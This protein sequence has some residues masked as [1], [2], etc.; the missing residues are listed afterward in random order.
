MIKDFNLSP[1][2]KD[3][4][5][6]SLLIIAVTILCLPAMMGWSG[7]FFDDRATEMLPKVYF[8][9]HN[10]QRGIIPLWNPH[11]WCG[12]VPFYA[13]YYSLVYYL[14]MWPFYL[15]ANLNDINQTYWI[16][17]ILSL[18]LY[19]VI[20]AVGMYV[21]LRYILKY[22]CITSFLGAFIYIYSPSFIYA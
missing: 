16:T 7:I 4:L 11:I 17:V 5:A 22:S 6:V 2:N 1:V 14:P 12:A 13:N 21:L 19:Y 10:L 9:A 8:I 3:T 15:F 18:W 20:T